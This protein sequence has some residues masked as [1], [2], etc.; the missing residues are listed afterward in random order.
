MTTPSDPPAE[1]GR[2]TAPG[3]SSTPAE[4]APADEAADPQETATETP[5]ETSPS[6]AETA[7]ADTA[8]VKPRDEDADGAGTDSADGAEV[9]ADSAET[10]SAGTDGED[11]DDVGPD[12]VHEEHGRRRSATVMRTVLDYLV[13][14]TVAIVIAVLIK[15]F[16]VQPFYVPS[17]SMRPT[18]LEQDKILVSKLHPDLL[19][20]ERGDVIVFEDPSDWVGAPDPNA[21]LTVRQ[22][23][24]KVLSVVGLTPDPSQRFLVKRLIGKPGDTISCS[25]VGGPMSVNG[26]ELEEPYI[27]AD[28]GACQAVFSVTVPSGK[29]WVMGDNRFSSADSAYRYARGQ[30]AFIPESHVVGRAIVIMW[31]MNRWT[32]L[33][34]ADPAFAPLNSAAGDRTAATYIPAA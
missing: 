31:P 4:A 21:K 6:E 18:L 24:Q 25:E 32:V 5:A 23:A 14:I 17:G 22:A 33:N 19:S 2:T 1:P 10:D 27:N 29:L 28:S 7:S 11:R 16:L 30:D 13:T 15:T 34:E 8:D 26:H 12:A 3:S 20:L 9:A